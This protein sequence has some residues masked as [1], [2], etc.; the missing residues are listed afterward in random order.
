MQFRNPRTGNVVRCDGGGAFL[1]WEREQNRNNC[2]A[3]AI[4]AGYEIEQ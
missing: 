4:A 2:V 1:A 3:A